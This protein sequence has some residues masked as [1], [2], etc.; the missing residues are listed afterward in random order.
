MRKNK[1]LLARSGR[2]QRSSIALPVRSSIKA[3]PS[4]EVFCV[5]LEWERWLIRMVFLQNPKWASVVP[6]FTQILLDDHQNLI[7]LA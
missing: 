4:V 1:N 7:R 3:L 6:D 2:L 5:Q